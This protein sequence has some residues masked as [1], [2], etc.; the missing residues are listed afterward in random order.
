MN[1]K[2]SDS[3]ISSR[4]LV[5]ALDQNDSVKKIVKQSADDLT[6]VNA[7][8]EKGIPEQAK[9]GDLAQALEKTEAIEA[10]IQGSAKDLAEV[11]QLLEHEVDERISL[12]R[13]LLT[14]KAALSR[15]EAELKK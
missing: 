10:T 11:N 7:V 6:V 2:T 9:M 1:K 4:A 13:E 3:R 15:A 8:L 12:E 5:K 14:T